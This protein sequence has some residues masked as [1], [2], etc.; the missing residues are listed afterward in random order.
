MSIR[1]VQRVLPSGARLLLRRT[2]PE[3]KT[4]EG[5]ILPEKGKEKPMTAVVIEVGPGEFCPETREMRRPH[6]DKGDVVLIS[7]WGGTTIE[8]DGKEHLVIQADEVLGT[9]TFKE[10][11][12]K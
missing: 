7:K 11:A 10:P 4:P 12:K 1:N 2:D 9:V 6:F 5:I 3:D 8:I